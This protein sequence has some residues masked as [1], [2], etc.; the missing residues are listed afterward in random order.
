VSL[1]SS[2]V[3]SVARIRKANQRD[4]Q[5]II[6]FAKKLS[7]KE[8]T[9]DPMVMPVSRFQ[10]HDWLMKNILGENS[11]VFVAER[12]GTLV[13]YV[14]GWIDRPC[15][16]RGKRG[17]ICDCFV[18]EDYRHK[19]I[20]T[21]LC[22]AILEWF[23]EKGVWCVESDVHPENHESIRMFEGLGFKEVSKRFRLPL[24]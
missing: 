21:G 20:G 16:Y 15:D 9:S 13:G 5:V 4:V 11:I 24:A 2:G 7:A 12:E 17:Y 14:L 22:N 19:G 10:D 8:S 18:L 23:R 6:E 1:E 3:E